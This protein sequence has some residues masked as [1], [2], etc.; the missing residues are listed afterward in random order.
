[1]PVKFIVNNPQLQAYLQ[2]HQTA[3]SLIKCEEKVLGAEGL[4]PERFAVMMAIKNLPS[5]VIESDI[6]DCLDRNLNSI[7][8][9]V[10]RMTKDG[11][12][13]RARDLK[14]RRE[15]RIIITPKGEE[16]YQK[17]QQFIS[18]I[19]SEIMF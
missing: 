15:I 18:K 10:D 2:I 16:T 14:D 5:P 8:L 19:V 13:K 1:M 12:I 9:I 6:A 4:T 17:G 7:T 3:V 11:L